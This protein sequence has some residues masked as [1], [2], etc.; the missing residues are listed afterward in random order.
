[1]ADPYPA[2]NNS[3]VISNNITKLHN[4]EIALQCKRTIYTILVGTE[5][6][7]KLKTII[8]PDQL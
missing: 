7:F 6:E 5:K 8:I 3:E 4:Q 2:V 1:M